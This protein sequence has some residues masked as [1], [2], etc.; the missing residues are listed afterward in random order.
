MLSYAEIDD[1]ITNLLDSIGLQHSFCKIIRDLDIA[2]CQLENST[3]DAAGHHAKKVITALT[4]VQQRLV[5]EIDLCQ[6]QELATAIELATDK[7]IEANCLDTIPS[8]GYSS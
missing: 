6:E 4:H 3:D 1:I 8:N 5:K 7:I 2:R